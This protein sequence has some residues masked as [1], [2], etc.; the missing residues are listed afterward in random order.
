MYL[1]MIIIH[2]SLPTRKCSR[3]VS[4]KVNRIKNT[5]SSSF[6]IIVMADLSFSWSRQHNTSQHIQ[7]LVTAHW[8]LIRIED[9]AMGLI[10]KPTIRFKLSPPCRALVWLNRSSAPR[11]VHTFY[12]KLRTTGIPNIPHGN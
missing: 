10:W 5:I 9:I 2:N 4:K 6:T 3:W 1:L 7:F 11:S 8:I 12:S